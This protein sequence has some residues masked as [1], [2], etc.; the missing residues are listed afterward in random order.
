MPADV[1]T[2]VL[3]T[4]ECAYIESDSILFMLYPYLKFPYFVLG[5]LALY[6]IPRVLRDV[7]YRLFARNRGKIWK[8]VKKITGMGDTAM[9]PY[10]DSVLGLE[11]EEFIPES[12]GFERT[13]HP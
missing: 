10:R 13:A 8:V 7:G 6:L 11:N 3:F 1:S 5:F 2:A 9:H 12:W 4:E